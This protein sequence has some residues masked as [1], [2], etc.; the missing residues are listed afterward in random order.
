VPDWHEQPVRV[1]GR[2]P[3]PR[4]PA[5]ALA[6]P[7]RHRLPQGDTV[8]TLLQTCKP[9]SCQTCHPGPRPSPPQRTGCETCPSTRTSMAYT[10]L[11]YTSH[12]PHPTS[13]IP[14][15]TCASHIR[16]APYGPAPYAHGPEFLQQ[17]IPTDRRIIQFPGVQEEGVG[18]QAHVL[19][20]LGNLLA[21]AVDRCACSRSRPARILSCGQQT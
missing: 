7:H 14:H 6:A 15:P 18:R 5:A 13:H 20:A 2:R 16:P 4:T 9:G 17:G 10:D 3:G 21:G 1:A 11:A 19:P 8:T 12:I